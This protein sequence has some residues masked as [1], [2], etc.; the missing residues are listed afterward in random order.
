MTGEA[1]KMDHEY[2]SFLA[3][4]GGGPPPPDPSSTPASRGEQGLQGG[5]NRCSLQAA[6]SVLLAEQS[7]AWLCSRELRFKGSSMDHAWIMRIVCARP[8]Q[9][10][11]PRVEAD[12]LN[13]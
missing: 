1:V 9:H 5:H 4:L 2:K 11:L 6:W 8:W 12:S 3:E 10:P 7:S 13:K